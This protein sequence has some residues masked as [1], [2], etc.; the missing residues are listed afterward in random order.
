MAPKEKASRRSPIQQRIVK[1]FS[2]GKSSFSPA[3]GFK[4]P[5]PYIC[6]LSR[7]TPPNPNGP[8][9]NSQLLTFENHADPAPGA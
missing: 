6:M 1:A 5:N 9:Y 8:C 3:S 7:A 4:T 2:Y